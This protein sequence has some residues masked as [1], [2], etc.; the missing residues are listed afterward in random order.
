MS[1]VPW[2]PFWEMDKWFEEEPGLWKRFEDDL[3]LIQAPRMDIYKT[4]KDVVAE[5]EL[6]GV[7]PEKIS[8]EVENGVL[9]IEAGQEKK[10]E[11]KEKDYYRKEI[12]S[13]YYKRTVPLP[14]EVKEKKAKATYEDGVLKVI[15]PRKETKKK[16]SKKIKI[17]VKRSKK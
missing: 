8:A 12:S 4:K 9:K 6:P 5:I 14:A 13:S 3:S 2:R 15:I 1:L 17:K 7:D 11:E 16:K 10:K